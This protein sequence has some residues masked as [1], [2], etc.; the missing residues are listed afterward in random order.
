MI[1]ERRQKTAKKSRKKKIND[2]PLL[3]TYADLEERGFGSRISIWRNVK[4]QRFPAPIYINNRPRWLE[5]VILE[6]LES[7]KQV[8]A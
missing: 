6:F 3:L 1:N 7:L 2:V 8:T 5:P 4:S